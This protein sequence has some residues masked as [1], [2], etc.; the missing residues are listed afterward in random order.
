MRILK[1]VGLGKSTIHRLTMT[2]NSRSRCDSS[3]GE[4]NEFVSVEKRGR[5]KISKF[6][7]EKSIPLRINNRENLSDEKNNN[8]IKNKKVL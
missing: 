7:S 3:R 2:I 6:K 1:K 8:K 4:D 5:N